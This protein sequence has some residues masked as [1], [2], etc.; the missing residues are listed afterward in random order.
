MMS[1]YCVGEIY[2]YVSEKTPSFSDEDESE[3]QAREECFSPLIA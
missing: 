2:I 1:Y 3:R